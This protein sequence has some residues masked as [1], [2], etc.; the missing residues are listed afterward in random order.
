MKTLFRYGMALAAGAFL[1]VNTN[2]KNN[3]EVVDAAQEAQYNIV[4]NNHP[5]QG[6]TLVQSQAESAC[7]GGFMLCAERTPGSPQT[8]PE[9]LEWEGATTKF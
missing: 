5:N 1:Y 6:Q 3:E 2:A 8:A 4:A 9:T 7:P